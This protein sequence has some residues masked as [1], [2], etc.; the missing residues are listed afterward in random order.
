MALQLGA[1]LGSIYFLSLSLYK[2]VVYTQRER[3][4]EGEGDACVCVIRAGRA[5]VKAT[6]E[7]RGDTD[8]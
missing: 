2:G 5:R 4:G 8:G 3:R 1:L 7:K 6:R